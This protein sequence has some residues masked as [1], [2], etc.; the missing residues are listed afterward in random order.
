[1]ILYLSHKTAKDLII[2][3]VKEIF[4][5]DELRD[6]LN[7]E[8]LP[9]ANSILWHMQEYILTLIKDKNLPF[10][11]PIGLNDHDRLRKAGLGGGLEPMSYF[12]FKMAF[13]NDARYGK[14]WLQDYSNFKE[15]LPIVPV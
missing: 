5:I 14:E 10:D 3:K 7:Y 2:S 12:L 8:V 15:Y 1:M 4:G 6:M 13:E 9:F 11:N